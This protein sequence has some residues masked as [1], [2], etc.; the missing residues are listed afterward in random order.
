MLRKKFKVTSFL[1]LSFLV[2]QE[3]DIGHSK[4]NIDS[5]LARYSSS[6]DTIMTQE[7]TRTAPPKI[8]TK[9]GEGL[10]SI[11]YNASLVSYDKNWVN[12]LVFYE[13]GSEERELYRLQLSKSGEGSINDRRLLSK[14]KDNQIVSARVEAY[15]LNKKQADF[16]YKSTP[17]YTNKSYDLVIRE[18]EK[19]VYNEKIK[20]I[21]TQVINGKLNINFNN[22]KKYSLDRFYS[23]ENSK[24][25]VDGDPVDIRDGLIEIPYQAKD[26]RIDLGKNLSTWN[27]ATIEY[28]KFLGQENKVF[29]IKSLTSFAD[30]RVEHQKDIDN[31][32]EVKDN[33]IFSHYEV[34]GQN[35]NSYNNIVNSNISIKAI[36]STKI[37]IKKD[38]NEDIVYLKTGDKL[39]K[40]AEDKFVKPDYNIISYNIIDNETNK[41]ENVASIDDLSVD[42]SITIEPVYEPKKH[43]IMLRQDNYNKRFGRVEKELEN[44]DVQ[45]EAT[46]PLSEFLNQIREKI[47][48]NEG[49]SLEFRIARKAISPDQFIKEDT[50]LE[51]YFKKKEEGWVNVKF[52]GEGIDKFLSDGQDVLAGQRIDS[53]NL[54]TSQG[55]NKELVGW[56]ANNN[57]KYQV[58]NKIINKEKDSIIKTVDLPHVVTSKG[59]DLVFTAK[60]LD[61]YKVT[62]SAV[63]Y[64]KVLLANS[65]NSFDV[66]E[67]QRIKDIVKDNKLI[68]SANSHF[69]FSHF[70]A[71]HDLMIRD[72]ESGIKVISK[73]QKISLKDFYNI[74][75]Q[76]N[77]EIKAH[78][79]FYDGGLSLDSPLLNDGEDLLSVTAKKD[80]ND[81]IEAALGPLSF[82]R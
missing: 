44:L 39:S 33:Y 55:T 48:P 74:V 65:D 77:L 34:N 61:N 56:T 76:R 15:D 35:I 82:L 43:K 41:K 31:L 71:N 12:Y 46:K 13:Q 49:Y 11:S 38:K 29:D 10:E 69:Q 26:I 63:A 5:N 21:D 2:Y 53:I 62:L 28:P 19:V 24:L 57:Y 50:L 22:L 18:D 54:P 25:F 45:W 60:Y 7:V 6:S 37:Y 52:T 59:Q 67:G 79:T 68:L 32:P 73:G 66:K 9:L 36:Y 42:S 51:I 4:I 30:F 75:V 17:Y 27:K 80:Y 20:D 64:G 58:N 1:I 16:S 47:K 8:E 3:G 72:E 40:I 70:T 81:N 23:Y 14:I 78:F